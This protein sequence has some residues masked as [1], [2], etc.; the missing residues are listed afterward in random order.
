MSP[1]D[2]TRTSRRRTLDLVRVGAV[3]VAGL[4]LVLSAVV[5]LGASPSPA[6]QPAASAGTEAKPGKVDRPSL[7][8]LEGVRD[9][10]KGGRGLG[11]FG[12]VA[13]VGSSRDHDHEDRRLDDRAEDR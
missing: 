12:G 9:L 10:L 1:D 6:G 7:K 2:P 11:G 3:A 4:A 8:F 5:A 13:G